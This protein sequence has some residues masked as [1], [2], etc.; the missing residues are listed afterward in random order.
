MKSNEKVELWEKITAV[1]VVMLRGYQKGRTKFE[2]VEL[3]L[4]GS[5][6]VNMQNKTE[7]S[8]SFRH[9]FPPT[10]Q[11]L[12]HLL[13]PPFSIVFGVRVLRYGFSSG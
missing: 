2:M 8:N 1:V 7:K 6:K 3:A 9:R 5:D 12:F 4:S 11:H 10:T 13:P